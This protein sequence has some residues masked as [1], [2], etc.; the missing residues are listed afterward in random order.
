MATT[1][2]LRASSKWLCTGALCLLAGCA[3]SPLFYPDV[4]G[5]EPLDTGTHRLTPTD[6]LSMTTTPDLLALDQDMRDFARRYVHSIGTERQQ[7]KT[8]Q[9]S[10]LSPAMRGVEY[11]ADADGTAAEVF[12]DRRANCLSYAHL[13]VAMARHVGLNASYHAMEMRPDWARHGERVAR[14]QHVNVLVELRSGE[15]YLVDIDPVA[16][17]AVAGTRRISDAQAFA[18]YHNNLA[19]EALLEDDTTVAYA[20]AVRALDLSG[21]TEYL[22]VNLGAIYRRAQQSAAAEESYVTAL[23]LKPESSSAMNN[24][25]V[26]YQADGRTEE[27]RYWEEQVASYR[28]RN[29][30][31]HSFLGLEAARDGDYEGA[32]RHYLEA[33]S[34]KDEDADFYYQLGRLYYQLQQPDNS[35]RYLEKAIERAR[36][37]A[38]RDTY[39][40]FLA[41]VTEQ[42]LALR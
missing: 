33:I 17:T 39:R 23:R 2:Y 40:A 13:F 22:W 29:P 35:I 1:N 4:H 15:Q 30:Y 42:R 38:D 21:R 27:A 11:A 20:E 8:L 9:R 36:L 7:L 37:R 12:R 31:Y 3:G 41:Q 16:R 24:L 10:L 34:L 32:T 14:R 19:M 6:A 25:A 28:R 5:L 18:L 26:L